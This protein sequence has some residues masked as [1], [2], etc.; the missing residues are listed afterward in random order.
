[1]K[2]SP[3]LFNTAMVQAILE[4]RKTQTR[5][6]VNPQ[7][8]VDACNP[9][10]DY[11]DYDHNVGFKGRYVSFENDMEF[12][13]RSRLGKV[14]DLLWVRETFC[15]FVKDHAITSKYAYKANCDEE[16]ERCRQ[17]YIAA[18]YPYQ[19]KP[20]IF[21]PKDACRIWLE[22]KDV[23]V[24]RLNDISQSDSEQEGVKAKSPFA[25]GYFKNLWDS[26]NG[27]PRADGSDIS[28][29]ANPW[30]WVYEFKVVET[31]RTSE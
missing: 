4:G 1:M 19:W 6:V 5:R 28:W 24:E 3:I 9:I 2:Q 17:D 10:L 20:S 21:M 8:S 23:R 16:S 15:R 22:I 14:G 25:I 12:A 30:V 26:I 27:K 18:G 11:C 7:P 13:V 29:A 31:P